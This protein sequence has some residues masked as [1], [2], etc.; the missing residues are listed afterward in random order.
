MLSKSHL[1]PSASL[2]RLEKLSTPRVR[3]SLVQVCSSAARV[4]R[5]PLRAE[6]LGQRPVRQVG[7]LQGDGLQSRKWVVAV[8]GA[9]FSC[10]LQQKLLSATSVDPEC[11]VSVSTLVATTHS[12]SYF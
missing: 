1:V 12:F 9:P 7:E 3:P 8:P 5:G 6:G 10:C 11:D 4:R 2:P